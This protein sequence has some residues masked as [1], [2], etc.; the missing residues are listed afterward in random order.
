MSKSIR[1]KVEAIKE[2]FTSTMTLSSLTA[3]VE[4]RKMPLLSKA[5]L[6]AKT[7]NYLRQQFGVKD[8]AQLNLMDGT[9]VL[10]EGKACA[11]NA[12]GT[13]TFTQRKL[14]TGLIK[15]Q[16][17][18]CNKDFWEHYMNEMV[19]AAA[20]DTELVFEKELIE[21]EMALIQEANEKLIWQGD[22]TS[23]TA[24]LAHIDG[25]VKLIDAASTVDEIKAAMPQG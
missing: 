4:E 8:S 5:I 24:N 7:A 12:E 6:Q 2:Q 19:K 13:N 9:T 17:S 20:N 14:Q 1:E 3:Y 15:V 23:G 11:W 10:Q 25:L 16:K 18:F 21:R 22:T